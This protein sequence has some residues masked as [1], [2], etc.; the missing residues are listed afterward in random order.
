MQFIVH[1]HLASTTSYVVYN[2]GRRM[3]YFL[4][5]E[6]YVSG[7][8]Y[9]YHYM[10]DHFKNENFDFK[11]NFMINQSEGEQ[12]LEFEEFYKEYKIF[13]KAKNKDSKWIIQ[14]NIAKKTVEKIFSKHIENQINLMENKLGISTFKELYDSGN[15][16]FYA[17]EGSEIQDQEDVIIPL[18]EIV[19]LQIA[20]EEDDSPILFLGNE[21]KFG[22]EHI[23]FETNDILKK[24]YKNG[25]LVDV[26]QFPYSADVQAAELKAI[27]HEFSKEI[28]PIKEQLNK[29]AKMAFE[30]PT[31]KESQQFFIKNILPKIDD[32]KRTIFNISTAQDLINR[33]PAE[34]S[35]HLQ[36]GELPI[37]KIWEYYKV[38]NHITEE[39]YQNLLKLKKENPKK[40]AGR[41]P[42]VVFKNDYKEIYLTQ[43]EDREEEA[44]KTRKTLDID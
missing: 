24:D 34:Y 43:K 1:F 18:E 25:Y 17:F 6:M 31:S 23:D 32:A 11:I 42:V 8:G 36:F 4:D 40:Y 37:D 14:T 35:F 7:I 12:K 27:T 41:W 30:N 15:V 3:L 28:Q 33:H 10:Y 5:E 13:L 39:H 21:D 44:P 38:Y 22:K 9:S 26:F 19:S 2:L 20:D 29:W 16:F